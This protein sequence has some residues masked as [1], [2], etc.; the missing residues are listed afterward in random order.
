[1]MVPS[2]LDI[3]P[4]LTAVFSLP[5]VQSARKCLRV[6]L[7][8]EHLVGRE[9][10]V[11]RSD[12]FTLFRDLYKENFGI[13]IKDYSRPIDWNADKLDL[14][15]LCPPR[16]GF[17]IISDWRISDLRPGDV[18]CLAVGSSNANHFAIYVGDNKIIHHL[19]GRRSTEETLRDFWRMATCYVLRH[20]SV[21]DLRPHL[22]NTTIEEL[23][24]D[25]YRLQAEEEA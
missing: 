4:G 25:R 8:Y 24:R 16:E 20:P 3:K 5:N 6:T 9:F 14:L 17:E 23:L 22:P 15:R 1:M 13:E 18:L 2:E 21:P 11:N 7:K 12:C 19:N 10:E